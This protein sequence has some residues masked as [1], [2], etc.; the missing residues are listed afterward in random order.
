MG[1][2]VPELKPHMDTV[3]SRLKGTKRA[4]Y[5]EMELKKL[6]DGNSLHCHW[7]LFTMEIEGDATGYCYSSFS[8]LFRLVILSYSLSTYLER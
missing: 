5:A 4:Q 3:L 7:E 6:T 1:F 8:S 2:N